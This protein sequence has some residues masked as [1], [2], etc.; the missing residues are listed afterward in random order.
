MQSPATS[1]LSEIFALKGLSGNSTALPAHRLLQIANAVS[2][3]ETGEVPVKHFLSSLLD[4]LK[5]VFSSA[6]F[7]VLLIGPDKH[8]SFVNLAV[9][10]SP[11]QTSL[12]SKLR[13]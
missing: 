5:R 12:R 3:A 11:T 8:G 6:S 4:S 1:F 7:A 2:H 10:F 9:G 13:P